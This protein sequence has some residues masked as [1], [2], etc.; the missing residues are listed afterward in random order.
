MKFSVCSLFLVFCLLPI[1]SLA[2]TPGSKSATSLS[3]ALSEP[4][5]TFSTLANFTGSNGAHP[6]W[7]APLVQGIDG[8]GYGTTATGGTNNTCSSGG[9]GT[10]YKITPGGVLTTLYNF[11]S[12]Q[13]CTDGNFPSPLIQATDGN[14]YGVNAL[15]GKNS[16]CVS[17]NTSQGCGTVFRITPSGSLTTLYSFCSKANCA[18]GYLPYAR[19]TQASNGDLYGTTFYGGTSTNCQYEGES[20]CGTV[21]KIT[22]NGV[23][24]TLHSFNGTDGGPTFDWMIQARDGNLYGATTYY[25]PNSN[26][27]TIFK[28]TLAG[29]LTVLHSFCS[30]TNCA[31]GSGPY[32]G[33]LQGEDGNLYGTTVFGGANSYSECVIGCGTFFSITTSGTLKTIYSF[34]PQT[35]CPDG[36]NPYAGLVQAT[37]GSFYGAADAGANPGCTSGYGETGCG[38]LFKITPSGT[39]NTMYRFCS[40]TNC[41][42]GGNPSTTLLQATNGKFYSTTENGGS[43]GYGTVFSAA[44]GIGPFVVTEPTFGKVGTRVGILGQGFSTTTQVFFNGTKATIK[45]VKKTYLTATVPSGAKTGFVTVKTAGGTLKSNAKFYVKP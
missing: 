8:N 6:G 25:G 36:S 19:L 33:L 23:F 28:M 26:A 18:D 30:E 29:K 3:V 4:G 9:C 7:S 16:G 35:N 32:A 22:L 11:C 45:V 20:G 10:F 41:P 43:D 31:D 40:Q 15:G 12:Q 37:D 24:T 38:T 14:F 17:S 5:Q 1:A 13:N 39:L 34:C 44:T 2:Q 42:D 21:F 27:G